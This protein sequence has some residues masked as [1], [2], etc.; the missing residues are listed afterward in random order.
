MARHG[1]ELVRVEQLT[2]HGGSNRYWLRRAGAVALDAS[3]GRVLAEEEARG[4]LDPEV[5][6]EFREQSLAAIV[7]L[8]SWLDARRATGHASPPSAPPRRATPC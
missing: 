6:Q 3:V 1:L 4:L 2:T 5:W 8:R 7:G